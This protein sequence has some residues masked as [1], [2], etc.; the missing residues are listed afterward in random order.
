MNE[1]YEGTF[2]TRRAVTSMFDFTMKGF[3]YN[4]F[5]E[6]T[7]GLIKNADLS[8]GI[9]GEAERTHLDYLTDVGDPVYF[10]IEEV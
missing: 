5:C 3:V 10:N 8:M 7:K 2:E 1:E 9:T 6:P 4:K